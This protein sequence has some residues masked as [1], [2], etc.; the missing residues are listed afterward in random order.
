MVGGGF[1]FS[2]FSNK[3]EVTDFFSSFSL[4]VEF[5]KYFMVK[6]SENDSR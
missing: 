4:L 5:I 6:L 2:H 3:S 1:T